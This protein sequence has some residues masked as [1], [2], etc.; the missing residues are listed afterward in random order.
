VS[1][2]LGVP[3]SSFSLGKVCRERGA[4]EGEREGGKEGQ[5]GRKGEAGVGEWLRER[6]PACALAGGR[7]GGGHGEGGDRG[8]RKTGR[9]TLAPPPHTHTQ[10]RGPLMGGSTGLAV[11]L[12]SGHT[13]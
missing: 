5:S 9:L 12:L 13:F 3:L 8:E 2:D 1:L 11:V 6:A 4:E 10:M 7:V